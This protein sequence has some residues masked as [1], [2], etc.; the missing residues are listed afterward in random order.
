MNEPAELQKPDISKDGRHRIAVLSD[1][2][3][4]LREEVRELLRGCDAILHTGDIASREVY[5]EIGRIAPAYFVRG[6]ADKEWAEGI[7][8]ELDVE[9]YGYHFYMVH[10]KKHIR[11]ELDGVDFVIYGHSHKYEERC[12]DGV[13]YLNPGSCGPRRFTQLVT[14]AVLQI[15]ERQRAYSVHRIDFTD[16]TRKGKAGAVGENAAS[17]DA[18]R[19]DVAEPDMAKANMAE[20]DEAKP[21]AAELES[22]RRRC[23]RIHWTWTN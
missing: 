17:A 21:A 1:T 18:A 2:H 3:S 23:S 9:L 22:C 11:H 14:M 4:R 8:E 5:E 20:L 13:M 12:E 10:N 7:P 6:N 19:M 15:E 16:L